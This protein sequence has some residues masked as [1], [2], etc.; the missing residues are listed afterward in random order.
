MLAR[1][2]TLLGDHFHSYA[3]HDCGVGA[4]VPHLVRSALHTVKRATVERLRFRVLEFLDV[5]WRQ[6]PQIHL[7][8][9]LAELARERERAFVV[10]IVHGGAGIGTKVHALIPLEDER[11]GVLHLL[12]GDILAVN[13]K[14]AGARVADAAQVD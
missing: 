14:Q 1:F 11:D 10:L 2:F 12:G 13:L 6:L 5:L 7:D 3:G 8:R 9:D 4:A